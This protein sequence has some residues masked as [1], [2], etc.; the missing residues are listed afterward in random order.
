MFKRKLTFFINILIRFFFFA[1][2]EFIKIKWYRVEIVSM[3]QLDLSTFFFHSWLIIFIYL[4][5]YILVRG[6][7][8]MYISSIL[9]Y[10][11]KLV[12]Y[13]I[14]Q[15]NFFFIKFVTFSSFLENIFNIFLVLYVKSVLKYF[16]MLNHIF[17]YWIT[18]FFAKFL[19]I[20]NYFLFCFLSFLLYLKNIY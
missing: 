3:P 2:I 20:M 15:K 16:L 14:F 11:R 18:F 1:F 5:I 12:D 4:F 9:K 17:F 13:L 8:A 7:F 6:S 10:R 19:S